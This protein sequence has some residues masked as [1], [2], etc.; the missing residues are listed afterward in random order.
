MLKVSRGNLSPGQIMLKEMRAHDFCHF[1]IE[2]TTNEMILS[3]AYFISALE[4]NI[5]SEQNI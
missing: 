4:L 3:Y 1:S 2:K 5:N